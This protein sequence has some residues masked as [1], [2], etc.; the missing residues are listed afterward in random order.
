MLR[1]KKKRKRN[2]KEKRKNILEFNLFCATVYNFFVKKMRKKESKKEKRKRTKTDTFVVIY[3]KKSRNLDIT[4]LCVEIA[5]CRL[6]CEVHHDIF[7]P[8][9]DRCLLSLQGLY[10]LGDNSHLSQ[11]YQSDTWTASPCL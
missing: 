1:E 10:A 2:K 9:I 11:F 6:G 7:S 5:A 3:T 4:I 8:C